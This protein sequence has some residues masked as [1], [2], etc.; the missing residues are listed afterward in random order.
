MGSMLMGHL[1][2]SYDAGVRCVETVLQLTS[3]YAENQDVKRERHDSVE[4]C[5]L[6]ET[7]QSNVTLLPALS[8]EMVFATRS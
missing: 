8:S 5:P 6:A 3:T 7:L 1:R 4:S 2:A